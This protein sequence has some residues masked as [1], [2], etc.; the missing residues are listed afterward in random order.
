[1]KFATNPYH[2]THLT[3]GMFL[4]YLE[5][6]KIQMFYNFVVHPQI[7]KFSVFKIAR[8]LH[9]GILVANKIFRVTV[10]LLVYFCDQFV[11]PEFRHSR[12]RCS[13]RIMVYSN[14]NKILI[15]LL[16]EISMRKNSLF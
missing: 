3:L 7:L 1:M 12:C 4:H 6:L 14:E 13:V 9:T 11:A 2:V 10:L 8:E 5:K 16:F 15:K